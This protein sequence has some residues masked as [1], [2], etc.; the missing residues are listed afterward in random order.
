MRLF[1]RHKKPYT[2]KMRWP[3]LVCFYCICTGQRPIFHGKQV[4][5]LQIRTVISYLST[6]DAVEN[7]VLFTSFKTHLFSVDDGNIDLYFSRHVFCCVKF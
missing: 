2:Y 7:C 4:F 5:V 6:E 1:A 3:I